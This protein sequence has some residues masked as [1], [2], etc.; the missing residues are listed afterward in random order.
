MRQTAAHARG[1]DRPKG[2]TLGAHA[3]HIVLHL[4]GDGTLRHAGA[5]VCD[6]V[7][8]CRVRN[9]AR[10]PNTGDLVRILHLPQHIEIQCRLEC[11]PRQQL[12]ELHI[13][14]VGEHITLKSDRF[15]TVFFEQRRRLLIESFSLLYDFKRRRF[16]RSLLRVAAVCHEGKVI[17][18]HDKN[19]GVAAKSAEIMQI[20]LFRHE[21]GIQFPL[22][23]QR[24]QTL[25][26]RFHVHY[27]SSG[28]QRTTSSAAI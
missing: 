8:K 13:R 17:R 25:N 24:P 6:D 23:Q 9:L 12:L 4:G 1:E 7:R 27:I 16:L 22:G 26:T 28:R 19:C 11:N 21:H 18:R 10:A 5:D 14:A 15:H 20:D 2:G 3:A